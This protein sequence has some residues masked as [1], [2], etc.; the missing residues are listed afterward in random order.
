MINDPPPAQ[1]H[2]VPGYR[3]VVYMCNHIYINIYTERTNIS[4]SK[5]GNWFGETGPGEPM[6]SLREYLYREEGKPGDVL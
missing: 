6:G 3:L 4:T 2:D 5:Q 1:H